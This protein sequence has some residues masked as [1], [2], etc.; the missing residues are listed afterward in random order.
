MVRLTASPSSYNRADT[1]RVKYS[2]RE[3]EQRRYI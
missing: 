2:I 1:V 3:N